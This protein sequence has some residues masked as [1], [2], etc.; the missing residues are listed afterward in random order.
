MFHTSR[1]E[2]R[3]RVGP[4]NFFLELASFTI[5]DMRH[6]ANRTRKLAVILQFSPVYGLCYDTLTILEE[7]NTRNLAILPPSPSESRKSE[8][9]R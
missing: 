9:P 3:F 2:L 1:V 7:S 6:F 5:T 8:K 4:V